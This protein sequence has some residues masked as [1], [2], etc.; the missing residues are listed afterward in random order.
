MIVLRPQPTQEP[1]ATYT[2]HHKTEEHD[3]QDGRYSSHDGAQE[4]HALIGLGLFE[5]GVGVHH[6]D[7]T[8]GQLL[9]EVQDCR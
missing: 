6:E 2:V 3:S 8:S 9:E 7:V 4:G 5:D 1:Q